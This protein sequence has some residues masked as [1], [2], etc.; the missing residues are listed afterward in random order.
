MAQMPGK[1]TLTPR[2]RRDLETTL[3]TTRWVFTYRIGPKGLGGPD[4][5]TV[6]LPAISCAQSHRANRRSA[7]GGRTSTS[8]AESCGQDA[9]FVK[10]RLGSQI[11]TSLPPGQEGNAKRCGLTRTVGRST[12]ASSTSETNCIVPLLADMPPSTRMAGVASR[13]SVAGIGVHGREQI[14]DLIADVSTAARA[15]SFRVVPCV[16]PVMVPRAL[17]SSRVRRGRQRPARNRPATQGRLARQVRPFAQQ[18]DKSSPAT[19]QEGDE[20]QLFR[21]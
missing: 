12:C 2:R 6:R 14:A 11:Q 19:E 15:N 8:T 5:V 1:G 9:N 7:G 10:S 16:K 13:P 18:G 17:C 3:M 20:D 21:A 4:S